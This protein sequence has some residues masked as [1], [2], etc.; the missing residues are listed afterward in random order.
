MSE[1]GPEGMTISEVAHR[2]GINRGT[3]YQHF[4]TRDELAAAVKLDFGRELTA[5]LTDEDS[6][7]ERIDHFLEFFIDHPELGRL[8]IHDILTSPDGA[9]SESWSAYIATLAAFTKNGQTQDGID[10][11]MLGRILVGAPL[12]WSLWASRRAEDTDERRQLVKRFGREIKRLLLF[13]VMKPE[14]WPALV[15]EVETASSS[16]GDSPEHRGEH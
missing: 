4:R 8:W 3:A 2:A 7:S 9:P 5:M 16:S 6:L 12:V 11:E 15:A 10:P 14:A 13:G 1:R